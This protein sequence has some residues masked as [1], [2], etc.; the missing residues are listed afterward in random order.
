MSINTSHLTRQCHCLNVYIHFQ[1][2]LRISYKEASHFP[3]NN[4]IYLL[5]R[6][7]CKLIKFTLEMT[8]IRNS[9]SLNQTIK[10]NVDS[11]SLKSFRKQCKSNFP[12]MQTQEAFNRFNQYSH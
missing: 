8:R 2:M 3:L 5:N 9:Y 10:Q 7:K 11:H 6:A 12:P 4:C 1:F